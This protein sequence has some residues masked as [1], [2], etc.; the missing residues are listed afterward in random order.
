[1]FFNWDLPVSFPLMI[2]LGLWLLIGGPQRYRATLT[3]SHT[4]CQHGSPC[5]ADLGPP[6]GAVS[7]SLLQSQVALPAP[8]LSSLGGRRY[9]HVTLLKGEQLCPTS[10]K[11]NCLHILCGIVLQGRFLYSPPLMCSCIFIQSFSYI[12]QTH[13]YLFYT[14]GYI[15]ILLVY[16]FSNC[17]SF[18]HWELFPLLPVALC[19]PLPLPHPQIL[20]LFC[21]LTSTLA[22][23][24]AIGSSYLF[25]AP[26]ISP[27]K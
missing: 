7:V 23:Q 17:S 19:Y 13:G 8:T 14:L 2:S 24:G 16:F 26:A 11:V 9:M 5:G 27:K 22:L 25:P 15:P 21:A 3:A 12:I 10:L 20:W 6:A 18:G 1:M 4:C